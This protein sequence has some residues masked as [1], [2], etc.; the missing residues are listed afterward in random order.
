[1]AIEEK[2]FIED[3]EDDAEDVFNQISLV[4]KKKMEKPLPEGPKIIKEPIIAEK[5]KLVNV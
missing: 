4:E 1:L 5:P 3:D 2:K